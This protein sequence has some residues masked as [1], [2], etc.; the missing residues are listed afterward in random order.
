MNETA[1]RWR[2]ALPGGGAVRRRSGRARRRACCAAAPGRC[3]TRWLALLRGLLPAGAPVRRVPLG[4]ADDRLLGGLDL[5]G[6]A[7]A[8]AARSRSA[9]CWPRPTAACCCCRWPSGCRPAPPR[10]WPRRSTR[11]EVQLERDGIAPRCPARFGVVALDEGVARR[12]AAAAALADRLAFQLDL[13]GIGWRDVQPAS[14]RPA[15]ARGDRAR[16]RA[17]ARRVRADDAVL[18]A[19]CAAALALGIGSVRAPWCCAARARARRGAGRARQRRAR[20]R[21]AGRAPRA[22]AARDARCRRR[23]AAGR[24]GRDRRRPTAAGASRRNSRKRT[25]RQAVPDQPLDEQVLAAA[26]RPPCRPGCSPRLQLAGSAPAGARAPMAGPARDAHGAGAA[27]RPAR[28]P[29]SSQ[30]GAR[31][32]LVETLRAAAPWQR[33]APRASAA[34]RRRACAVRPRGLPHRALPAAQ[35][36]PPPSSSSTPPARRRCTGW[37]RPRARSS[38]CWPTATCGATRSR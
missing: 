24:A 36:R 23:R 4:I 13:D 5:A 6:H 9:A 18:E 1:A 30:R 37:P 19:L 26:A 3:A 7:A 25:Q 34:G 27:G 12:R 17:A 11:G 8:R 16:A 28:A 35:P 14:R 22:R 29:A 31:L 15:H 32:D 10:G 20:R 21:R 38:C 33:A 2:D